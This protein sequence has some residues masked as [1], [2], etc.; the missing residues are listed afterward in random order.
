MAEEICYGIRNE[1]RIEYENKMRTCCGDVFLATRLKIQKKGKV[2]SLTIPMKNYGF[3][4]V[5]L[6]VVIAIIGMLVGLLLPAVQQAREAARQMQCNNHLRQ[7]GLAALNLETSHQIFPSGGW[8]PQW[9]GDPDLGFRGNQPGSWCYSLL[10]YLEQ[11]AL[12]SLGQNGVEEFDD[13]QKEQAAIR[14]GVVVSLFY[15]P[16]RRPALVYPFNGSTSPVNMSAITHCCKTDYAA[17]SAD[18]YDGV[19]FGVKTVAAGKSAVVNGGKTGIVS[20]K[21]EVSIAEVQDGTSNT[22]LFGEKFVDPQYYT[23]PKKDGNDDTV[24]WVGVNDDVLRYTL[25]NET[26]TYCP[27]QDRVGLET[28]KAFGSAHAGAWGVVMCDGS[29]HRVSYSIDAKIHSYLGKKADREP[30]Q[31]PE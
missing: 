6:L 26:R 30:V 2:H 20:G 8:Y 4:L 31:L 25:Y 19:G 7:Q 10:P 1:V 15:C 18:G 28:A 5:E 9:V 23:S 22:Y 3:T 29:V 11:Q 21:S 24:A 17:N 27:Y 12:W 14:A 13:V 16:S